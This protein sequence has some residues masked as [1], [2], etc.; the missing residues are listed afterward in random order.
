MWVRLA[1]EKEEEGEN[2]KRAENKQTMRHIG[3]I[4]IS[5]NTFRGWVDGHSSDGLVVW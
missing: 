4:N 5:L 1:A 3:L 2:R